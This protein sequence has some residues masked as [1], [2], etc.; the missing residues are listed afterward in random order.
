VPREEREGGERLSENRTAPFRPSATLRSLKD[1]A[2]SLLPRRL[3]FSQASRPVVAP[4]A[5]AAPLP[6]LG[7]SVRR[8][9]KRVSAVEEGGQERKAKEPGGQ[10]SQGSQGSQGAREP[11]SRTT[12]LLG[13]E[14][15]PAAD[16]MAG[17]GDGWACAAE[18][19]YRPAVAS[20]SVEEEFERVLCLVSCIIVCVPMSVTYVTS[21][22][23]DAL[24]CSALLCSVW[25]AGSSAAKSAGSSSRFLTARQ[26]QRA[27]ERG[28]GVVSGEVTSWE[29]NTRPGQAQQ[30]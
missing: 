25:L 19:I 18:S 30:C 28:L 5:A 11:S 14:T 26:T 6:T 13:K 29:R 12:G 23:D 22:L 24:L 9:A 2:L 10:G 16:W 1:G 17:P 15:A 7:L 3:R 27:E 21:S 8:V 4:K 20:C